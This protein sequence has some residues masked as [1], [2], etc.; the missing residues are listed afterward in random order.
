MSAIHRPRSAVLTLTG[1]E[2]S[3]ASAFGGTNHIIRQIEIQSYTTNTNVT[4][5][6]QAGDVTNAGVEL[7][8]SSNGTTPPPPW[9]PMPFGTGEIAAADLFVKGTNG[10]KIRILILA[11]TVAS[12]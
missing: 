1:A 2:Q 6:G 3:I 8:V 11:R 4:H 12:S 9:A 10:E 7:P 5:V